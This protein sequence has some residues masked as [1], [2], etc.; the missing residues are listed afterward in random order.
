MKGSAAPKTWTAGSLLKEL[1]SELG[2]CAQIDFEFSLLLKQG[3]VEDS[4]RFSCW[5]E[6]SDFQAFEPIERVLKRLDAPLSVIE[7][8]QKAE[9]PV[10]QG[11]GVDLTADC[12]EFRLYLHG[13]ST[14]TL[15]DHYQGW[16][17]CQGSAPQCLHYTFHFL[18]ET[19]SGQRPLDII[20]VRLRPPFALL[21]SDKR[22][23]QSSGFWIRKWHNGNIDQLDLTFP[24]CPVAGTLPGLLKLAELL[25]L[26]INEPSRWSELSI[27]HV[28]VRV[29]LA[30]SIVT[31]YASA[32]LN[33][34]WPTSEAE[35]QE[36]VRRGALAFHQTVEAEVYQ[37]IPPLVFFSKDRAKIDSFYDGALSTW[38][39]VLGPKLHYHAGLF[40]K[41]EREPD[42][43]AM[44]AALDRAVTELY[45]F[46]PV[47]GQ[48]YDIGCGW[49]GA[50]AMWIHDLG[51]PSLGLTIS[52]E[53]FRYIAQLGLPV[54]LGNA[55]NTLPP[56]HFDCVILLE[57]LSHIYNKAWLLKVLR[58][59]ANRLVMRVNCQDSFPAS[60]AF[61]GTM[62]MVSST[63][64]RE[65][66][67]NS[68]WHIR[69]WRD[70]RQE[71]L[72]SVAVWHRRLQHIPYTNNRHIEVLRTWCAKIMTASKAWAQHNPLI[73]VVAD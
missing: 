30:S 9:M 41:P 72:P 16:R 58:L 10:R 33:E 18:P 29:G 37:H 46:L 38:Q 48:L 61:G 7:A 40:D 64:L 11:I 23:Q 12:P 49:G 71:A 36:Q 28:A 67:K 66:L 51:C 43:A 14:T 35:L 54:R 25:S 8:W 59:F 52:Q 39:S 13:R 6:G 2:S 15:A 42:D 5:L 57:S 1:G 32:S 50:L 20:D 56:S 34:S 68:G 19:P 31:L 69:H 3:N 60:T 55:E 63:T 24:W 22:L 4:G 47:N 45:P 21:L 73:E 27:R 70:R 17:W 62:Y 26:P 44:D 53:Q 65:I